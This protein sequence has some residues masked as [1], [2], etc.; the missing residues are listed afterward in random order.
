MFKTK[1]FWIKFAIAFFAA[2]LFVCLTIFVFLRGTFSNIYV[3]KGD[4]CFDTGNFD[5]AIEHYTTAKSWKAKNQNVYLGLAKTYAAKEDFTKAAQIID[6]AI[7]KKATTK[8]TGLE[9][10]YLMKIKIYTA[11]GMFSTALDYIGNFEDQYILKKIQAARPSDLTYSPTQGSYDHTLKMKIDVR[12][13][14]TVYYTT[15]GTTPTKFSNTYNAPINIGNGTTTITAVSIG[16]DGLISP[17]LSVTYEVTNANQPVEFDDEKIEKM[18]RNALS[19]PRG[20]I[21]VK[22]LETI[23]ELTN[24]NVTGFV[25]TLSDLDFMPNLESLSLFGEKHITSISQLSGK[26]KLKTLWLSGC[27]LDSE[28]INALGSLSALEFLDLSGNNITSI[29]ALSELTNLKFVYL[30]NNKIADLTPLSKSKNIE[31]ISASNNNLTAI[32]DFDSALKLTTLLVNKNRISDISTIHRLEALTFLDVGN[33]L[34]KNGKNIESLINLET[35]VICDNTLTNFDFLESLTK[36]TMLDVKNTDF[37]SLR[38]I[39]KLNITSLDASG[40]ELT[41]LS[42]IENFKSLTYLVIADTF[43]T[44][45]SPLA[46]LESLDYL[47]ISNL[48]LKDISVLFNMKNLNTIKAAGF[49]FQ[50]IV[51]ANPDIQI[52]Q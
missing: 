44:D 23:T 8:E 46:S 12:E 15:D 48:E 4:K 11:S 50:G 9:Q 35:L 52:I 6:E 47:D 28:K 30:E 5:T 45:I 3:K 19:K 25:H 38:P 22:E 27:A 42:G 37:M 14:E 41:N 51:F 43:V 34:I 2:A 7:E 49:N 10:L 33:N 21:L 26:T 18:V 13:G 20:T 31:F 39:E 40:T 17:K 24:D 32:P 29:S 16:S 36:L 1:Q